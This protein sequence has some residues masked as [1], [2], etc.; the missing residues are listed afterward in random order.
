MGSQLKLKDAVF[1]CLIKAAGQKLKA[2][3]VAE[4]IVENYPEQAATK[5]KNS[6]FIINHSQ[7]L[8]QLV[9]EIG[10]NRPQWEANNPE[11]R[12]T[13]DKPRRYYWS[14][15]SDE[16]LVNAAESIASISGPELS[17]LP[18][19]LELYDKLREFL[20]SEFGVHSMR[21]DEKTAS[22]K[23]GP[24]ANRWLFPDLC[25]LENLVNGYQQEVLS[26]LR[27]A[28]GRK[29][30]LW[31]FELKVVLNTSNVREAYFQAVSNSSWANFGY[32]VAAQIDE[33]V[34]SELRVLHNLHGIGVIQLDHENPT[35]SQT[36]IPSTPRQE[37]DWGAMNRLAEENSDFRRFSKLVRHFYQTDE[38]TAAAWK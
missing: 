26:L 20:L 21:I 7:L 18:L 38:L 33:K 11:F 34:M 12:T 35:E 37:V 23:K 2:R 9:A 32:L 16:E 14:R 6:S 5:M 15:V 8:N 29:G 22:N 36:L 4:W 28:G 17:A 24:N 10:S 31:S 19:E 13:A 27:L 3:D 1:A 25:G 30:H